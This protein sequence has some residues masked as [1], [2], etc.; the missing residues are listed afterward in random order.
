MPQP[1]GQRPAL[2]LGQATVCSNRLVEILTGVVEVQD[3]GQRAQALHPLPYPFGPISDKLYYVCIGRT[4]VSLNC[5]DEVLPRNT[6]Q[7]E[8]HKG[9]KSPDCLAV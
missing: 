9:R 2:G 8:L 4:V 1:L 6:T 3:L 7:Y 5:R